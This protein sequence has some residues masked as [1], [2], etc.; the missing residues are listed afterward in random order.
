MSHNWLDALGLQ[1]S[2]HYWDGTM[3]SARFHQSDRLLLDAVSQR[4]NQSRV[5][6]SALRKQREARR[7]AKLQATPQPRNPYKTYQTLRPTPALL[8]NE[9][10]HDAT[11]SFI[12]AKQFHLDPYASAASEVEKIRAE[13]ASDEW[14]AETSEEFFGKVLSTILKS[15]SKDLQENLRKLKVELLT[16][17]GLQLDQ[18]YEVH[19]PTVPQT[20]IL[21]AILDD[22]NHKIT[23]IQVT[24]KEE[25]AFEKLEA[26]RHEL[27]TIGNK[28]ASYGTVAPVL[29]GGAGYTQRLAPATYEDSMA[30]DSE[31]YNDQLDGDPIQTAFRDWSHET[32]GI[33]SFKQLEDNPALRDALRGFGEKFYSIANF[34]KVML[35]LVFAYFYGG[36]KGFL[37]LYQKWINN[38]FNGKPPEFIQNQIDDLATVRK[39]LTASEVA[40]EKAKIITIIASSV[41]AFPASAIKGLAT[42]PSKTK[43][44]PISIFERLENIRLTQSAKLQH[45]DAILMSEPV[46]NKNGVIVEES[47]VQIWN[48]NGFN[49]IWFGDKPIHTALMERI[50]EA[51]EKGGSAKAMTLAWDF[52]R[53]S[54]IIATSKSGMTR[55]ENAALGMSG[56]SFWGAVEKTTRGIGGLLFN[57]NQYALGSASLLV[58]HYATLNT[59]SSLIGNIIPKTLRSLTPNNAAL[60]REHF[61]KL[62]LRSG[63]FFQSIYTV[64]A[65]VAMGG[66]AL[67]TG[68]F[69]AK[70]IYST[71]TMSQ[72]EMFW[73][74][75]YGVKTLMTVPQLF[76][77]GIA[78]YFIAQSGMD[79]AEDTYM[80]LAGAHKLSDVLAMKYPELTP[81]QREEI[82]HKRFSSSSYIYRGG[83]QTEVHIA[84]PNGETFTYETGVPTV[85]LGNIKHA[86][87]LTF[88]EK[89]GL[90]YTD[91]TSAEKFF[92]QT[93]GIGMAVGSVLG[94]WYMA[95]YDTM[96]LAQ[97]FNGL[98]AVSAIAQTGHKYKNKIYAWAKETPVRLAQKKRELEAKKSKGLFD[99]VLAAGLAFF[100]GSDDQQQNQGE[101]Q[102]QL[103]SQEEATPLLTDPLDAASELYSGQITAANT[104]LEDSFL[105][106][107]PAA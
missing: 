7:T 50:S 44:E 51:Y 30:K 88:S 6:S 72:S 45:P 22:I 14:I 91:F 43:K 105:V 58:S 38:I 82:K 17:I 48:K 74:Y 89:G 77:S 2:Q 47:E 33:Q 15:S 21:R 94:A 42:K 49:E 37:K 90:E 68:D 59:T 103:D 106:T 27:L 95:S 57:A 56:E 86:L 13:Y 28:V 34:G 4:R 25:R 98:A 41:F 75:K 35:L 39:G 19:Q 73:A 79:Y 70:H 31:L 5:G 102:E 83:K 61:V 3:P 24:L 85:T 23:E 92:N 32:I 93:I 16:Q 29:E 99:K 63:F 96:P 104:R 84:I 52:F 46:K 76:A 12:V 78:V 1:T 60:G 69:D 101:Q 53:L 80:R 107:Q 62:G 64:G 100:S 81:E 11:P 10:N 71:L 40:K 26:R 54:L 20:T 18:Y 66:L 67:T 87:G 55:E 65:I 36:R 9:L 97:V 8:A